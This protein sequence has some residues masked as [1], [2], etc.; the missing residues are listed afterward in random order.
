MG[1]RCAP[2]RSQHVGTALAERWRATLLVALVLAVSLFGAVIGGVQRGNCLT[3]L[4]VMQHQRVPQ[5]Q[6]RHREH[7]SADHPKQLIHGANE[8]A[9][10]RP[11]VGRVDPPRLVVRGDGRAG[12]Q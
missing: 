12:P 8:H 5:D 2:A 4:P 6:Q 11:A 1:M 3:G 9:G 10:Q 7:Q